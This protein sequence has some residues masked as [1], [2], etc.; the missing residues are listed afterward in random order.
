MKFYIIGPDGGGN[1]IYYLM[2]EDGEG[3][4][5]HMC[6]HLGYA[7]GDLEANRPE[8]KKE[9]K[10]KFGKY[11]VLELGDDD[12]TLDVLTKKKSRDLT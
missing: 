3:L 9:W 11:E 5:S 2:S 10:K 6:S 8:R 4:A 1:G 12:M 7:R